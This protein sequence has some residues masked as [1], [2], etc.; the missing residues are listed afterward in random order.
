[1]ETRDALRISLEMDEQ[2]SNGQSEMYIQF[3]YIRFDFIA[4]FNNVN[5]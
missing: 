1:M 2:K 4:L 3:L 5:K